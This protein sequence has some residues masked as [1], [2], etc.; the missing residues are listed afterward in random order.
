MWD[1]AATALPA[2]AGC[3]GVALGTLDVGMTK[4]AGALYRYQV[5]AHTCASPADGALRARLMTTHPSALGTS[6][7]TPYKAAIRR[8]TS[9]ASPVAVAGKTVWLVCQGNS[10]SDHV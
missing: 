4:K 6:P 2:V 10:T 7:H 8:E 3:A 9:S 5:H 1:D